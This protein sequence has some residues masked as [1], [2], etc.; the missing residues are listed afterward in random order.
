[1]LVDIIKG[2]LPSELERFSRSYIENHT[3]ITV[4]YISINYLKTYYSIPKIKFE[5]DRLIKILNM[6]LGRI[7]IKLCD[8]GIIE[9][10]NSRTYKRVE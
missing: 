1:M 6:K 3:Y 8:E 5:R 9:T 7:L 2:I 10:F 4:K